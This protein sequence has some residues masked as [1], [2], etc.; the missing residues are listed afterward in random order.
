M[1]GKE[2][3]TIY[4]IS[5]KL[6]ISAATVSR[7]LNNSPRISVKTKE[8]VL[9]AA[10]EMNYK[11]NKLALA[12]KSGKSHNVGVII[13]FINRHFFSSVIR[14]IE[15]E[16]SPLGY[17]VII[18]QSHEKVETE[19]EQ[20]NT[21]LDAQIDGIFMSAS[22][23]TIDTEHI[24][25]VM[26]QNT[27]FVFFDRKKE[28]PGVS[29]VSIDDFN[30]A[31]GATVHLI[32]Q[33]CKRIAHFMGDTNIDVYDKRLQGYKSALERNGIAFDEELVVEASTGIEA[34]IQAVKNLWKLSEVP[35]AIFSS[36]DYSA[37]GAMQELKRKNVNIPEDVCIVGFSNEPFTEY[38]EPSMTTVDQSP[39]TMGK[40][41]AEVFLEQISGNRT[42]TI[43][44]K[45]V[46]PPS[47]II[48]NSSLRKKASK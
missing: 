47:L 21:L 17:R 4:D 2:K 7:A 5:K 42:V 36:S 10:K 22:K 1:K 48:R 34:G 43:E 19:I 39:K 32:E 24:S 11:Q 37:L 46:L 33:G 12:L 9:K 28:V 40:I 25:R 26:D 6:N 31:Y 20:I 13:P 44:K 41:A 8:L 14:G 38:L 3:I 18:C 23:T 27:P 35:D 45:V 29:A 16:L 15:D 30:G